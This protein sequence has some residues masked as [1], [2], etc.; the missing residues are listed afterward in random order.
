LFQK[1]YSL[2]FLLSGILFI[3]S[4]KSQFYN[5]PNDHNFAL[6]TEKVLAEKDSSIHSGI[7]PYIHFFSKKYEYLSDTQKV[8]KSTKNKKAQNLIFYKHFLLVEPKT[9]KFSLRIDPLLNLETGK[10]LSDSSNTTLFNNTRGLIA[11]GFIGDKVYF[12]SIISENQSVFPVYISDAAITSSIVP[13][14]GRWKPYKTTGY[15]YAFSSGFV[16]IQAT[17]NLNIQVG[18]GKQKIG[19]GYRSLLLSDNAFNYPYV[20][21][22]HQWFKG[23]VQYT[24]I[25]SVFMN[26]TSASKVVNP[27]TERLFQK[28]AASF[29]YLSWNTT[30]FLNIG[31][32]QGLIWQAGDD[33]NQ[34]HL[35]WQY[36]NPIIYTN[37][38]AYGLDNKNNILTGLD[39]KLKLNNSLNVYGQ[40]ML[41]DLNGT[42]WGYQA[43]V[44]YFNAFGIPNLFL[45]L[46]YNQVGKDSYNTTNAGGSDQS[47][48]HYNQNLAFTPGHGQEFVFIA[49]YKKKRV[50]ANL[51]YNY[52]SVPLTSAVSDYYSYVNIVNARIGY[53][54]NPSYNLNIYLGMLY[55]TQN[56]STF[57]LPNTETNY[58]YIGFKTS[59]YNLY[60]DF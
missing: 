38:F 5:L 1:K 34:Q 54:I 26:L 4:L 20:R 21:F 30:D 45:Q 51:R 17:K 12:E 58:I 53:L 7:K 3:P 42:A 50:F 48:S 52:Q 9:E 2:L 23:K 59:I 43:G 16:S 25:Y 44:N 47:Y 13:G 40:L 56:F 41:D 8:F 28:K 31:F 35:S 57:S 24:N 46:E 18:H 33:R 10:D 22:T 55:R 32:F 37:L 27:N 29:Q 15:D 36:F 19:N 49:D 14:Q 60:Y 11:S 6:L 39:A